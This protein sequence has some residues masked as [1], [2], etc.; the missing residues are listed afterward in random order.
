[1]SERS[2]VAGMGQRGPARRD[3]LPLFGTDPATLAASV[4]EDPTEPLAT[5]SP[6]VRDD[7]EPGPFPPAPDNAGALVAAAWPTLCLLAR[8]RAGATARPDG[9]KDGCIAA[10]RRF[11][12]EALRS[13]TAADLV[14]AGRYAICSAI[15]EQV[16]GT[17]WG[18]S[19]DWAASSLLSIF[20]NETWGGEKVFAIVDVAIA[21]NG[22]QRDL[23]LLLYYLLSLGFQ[24]RYRLRRD[25]TAE[26]EALRDRL[27]RALTPGLGAVPPPPGIAPMA[28]AATS[29]RRGIGNSRRL[30][31]WPP[32]WV[33]AAGSAV[34]GTL[35][36]V[37]YEALLQSRAERLARS[38]SAIERPITLPN[39][40][41]PAAPP[42]SAPLPPGQAAAAPPAAG[43]APGGFGSEA[44]APAAARPAPAPTPRWGRVPSRTSSPGGQ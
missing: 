37:T 17:P 5:A 31:S 32:V 15:D 18:D 26:V 34:F 16:L 24:G 27:Y 30:R 20:H 43:I 40:P 8:L 19:S 9:L 39:P 7:A 21:A 35:L 22:A 41:A 11:E 3:P 10:I 36:F 2:A 38:L 23:T 6:A 4:G 44:Q 13:G 28:L 42:V 25:G 29:S 14:F 1:M 33:V 12:S